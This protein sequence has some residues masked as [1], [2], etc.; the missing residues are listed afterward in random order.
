M[1]F[2]LYGG[3]FKAAFTDRSLWTDAS[4]RVVRNNQTSF[5]NFGGNF[6]GIFIQRRAIT[7]AVDKCMGSSKKWRLTYEIILYLL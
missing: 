2:G 3:F 5:D 7:H 6:V 1:S 4:I